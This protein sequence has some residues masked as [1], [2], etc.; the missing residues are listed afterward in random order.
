MSYSIK[1]TYITKIW[2][3]R[4]RQIGWTLITTLILIH[5]ADTLNV[6]VDMMGQGDNQ[7]IVLHAPQKRQWQT[8][9]IRMAEQ[10]VELLSETSQKL[11]MEIK[12]IETWISTILFEYSKRYH[13]NGSQVPCAL[14]PIS[15]I[16]SETN[17]GI[18]SLSSRITSIFSSGM[19]AANNDPTPDAAYIT[20]CVEA[21]TVICLE[22][23]TSDPD[24]VLP[25]LLVPRA[26]GG[27]GCLPFSAFCYR[28]HLDPLSASI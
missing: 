14:K 18:L 8:P 5:I 13:L 2:K 19:T 21:L 3:K 23:G 7:V 20:A 16:S 15:R 1:V 26:L 17:D 10:F 25:F 24:K 6:K 22:S 28:G 9:L 4:L 12:I 27:L 11:G